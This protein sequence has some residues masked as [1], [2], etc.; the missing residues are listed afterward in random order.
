MKKTATGIALSI[1]IIS[2][3]AHADTWRVSERLVSG[4]NYSSGTWNVAVQG[5]NLSG[6]ADMQVDNGTMLHYSLDGSISG[7]VY[8]VKLIGRDNDKKNC[9]WSGKPADG[10]S[11]KVIQ[12]QA[13]CE[14]T[15]L[16]IRGGVQ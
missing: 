8:T 16:Y 2:T 11:G 4:I 9:I 5:D 7:G 15:K 13:E 12:G 10:M 6:K 1:L 3:S 14:G